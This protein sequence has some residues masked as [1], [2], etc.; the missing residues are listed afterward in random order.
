MKAF[1]RATQA[2]Y[3][4]P[5]WRGETGAFFFMIYLSFSSFMAV[6]MAYAA[7]FFIVV[8]RTA[9]SMMIVVLS[10][11]IYTFSLLVYGAVHFRC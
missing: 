7:F 1:Y 8:K 4:V 9:S 5:L 10:L 3:S 6:L 11:L 2:T